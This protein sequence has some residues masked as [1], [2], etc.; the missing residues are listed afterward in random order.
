MD[1]GQIVTTITYSLNILLPFIAISLLF[2]SLKLHKIERNIAVSVST[3]LGVTSFFLCFFNLG[4]AFFISPSITPFGYNYVVAES[5]LSCENNK[6]SPSCNACNASDGNLDKDWEKI[7]SE[8]NPPY[9]NQDAL[10]SNR[11]HC[12]YC[13]W[14]YT[15][16]SMGKINYIDPKCK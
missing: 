4:L 7:K 13:E 3:L 1:S 2:F 11:S 8:S 12:T 5:Y 10:G 6:N 16:N 14:V 15:Q 9:Q